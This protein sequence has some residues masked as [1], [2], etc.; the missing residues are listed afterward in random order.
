MSAYQRSNR[1]AR[2]L[3]R[4]TA[5]DLARASSISVAT[6]RRAEL[7]DVETS[8]TA[9]N[10]LTIRKALEAAGVEFIDPNGGGPGV[11]CA[12]QVSLELTGI[13]LTWI[14]HLRMNVTPRYSSYG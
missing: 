2:S 9:A 3:V 8:L 5:D 13:Y 10:D 12:C 1:A 6:I 14:S 11:V 7:K 4:W